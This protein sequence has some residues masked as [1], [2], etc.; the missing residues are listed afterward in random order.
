LAASI[1]GHLTISGLTFYHTLLPGGDFGGTYTFALSSTSKAVNGLDTSNLSNNIGDNNTVVFSGTLPVRPLDG[2]VTIML[3]A[4]FTYDPAAGLNLLLD[5]T[6]LVPSSDGNV[7]DAN[8]RSNLFS[9]AFGP[10]RRRCSTTSQSRVP[11]P[12]SASASPD[13]A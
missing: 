9:R 4:P 12:F 11:S 1:P 5:V 7:F 8:S 3:S 2:S 13:L 6:G 10:M